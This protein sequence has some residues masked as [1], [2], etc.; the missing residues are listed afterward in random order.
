V[1]SPPGAVDI[2]SFGV[3]F[4]DRLHVV[5]ISLDPPPPPS[6]WSLPVPD[7]AGV[8]VRALAADGVA[9][10]SVSTGGTRLLAA[11]AKEALGAQLVA[12]RPVPAAVAGD[13]AA[14]RH[15]AG[16][17]ALAVPAPVCPEKQKKYICILLLFNV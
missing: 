13:A 11:L 9:V 1:K 17:L 12:A 16:L 5:T 7:P 15:L 3:V 2:E 4:V 10:V 6:L 14:L 8:A